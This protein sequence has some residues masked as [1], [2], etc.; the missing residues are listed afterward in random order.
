MTQK[1][2]AGLR[3]LLVE[4]E[5]LLAWDLEIA[6]AAAGATV[7]G[8]AN[9]L[10][11][12]CALARQR[13]LAAAILDVRLGRE[14]VGPL[15]AQLHEIGVPFLFHTGHGSKHE[16][17]QRWSAPVVNKPTDP[18]VIIRNVASLAKPNEAADS[19]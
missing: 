19:L 1:A 18:D 3:I 5:P 6:L 11:I 9:T 12:G 4:D 17:A 16:L 8:P 14:E 13:G 2:L 7:V 10:A 15:A